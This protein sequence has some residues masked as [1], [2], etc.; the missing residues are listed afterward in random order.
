SI[1]QT[2]AFVQTGNAE[3][4]FVALSQVQQGGQLKGGSMWVIPQ[5]LYEPIRQDAVVLRRGA[6][7]EA[8]QALMQLLKSPA[9][10]DLIRSYGYA[11]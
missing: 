1:G 10:K 8:A 9:I 4:G 7:N 2:F 6:S 3:L 11:A 5:S